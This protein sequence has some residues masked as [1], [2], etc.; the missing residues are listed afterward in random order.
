VIAVCVCACDRTAHRSLHVLMSEGGSA[1][2]LA[3]ETSQLQRKSAC[4]RVAVLL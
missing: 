1:P 3:D 2:L 4:V